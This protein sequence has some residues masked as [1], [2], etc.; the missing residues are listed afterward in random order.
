MDSQGNLF[1]AEEEIKLRDDKKTT[2]VN[3]REPLAARMRP[4]S[5]A[6]VVGQ[7]HLLEA[8]NLLPR[9]VETNSFG[10]LIFYGPPG[11]G[12]TSI[13][14]AIAAE[15]ESRYIRINAVMS[16]VAELREI[17][18]MARR[19]ET[20]DTVLFIDE[21][22]RFNRSQ[23]DLLLP[24]VEAGNIRLIGATTHNP[25]FYVN[26]P[27]LSRSH[28]FR[29]EPHSVEA[30]V[31][32]LQLALTDEERGL[33][34]RGHEA[35]DE[36]LEGLAK[37]CDGDMR[38]ALNAL[39]VISLGL[40]EGQPIDN[41]SVSVFA[42]ERQ[43]RYDANEDEHYN[44]ISAFIK[45]MRGGSPDSALYWLAKMMKGG[46]D[47]RFVARRLIVFCSEDIGLADAKALPLAVATQQACEFV[48]LP[49][50]EIN[51]AHCVAYC[52]AAPKSNTS[53]SAYGR[54]KANITAG[55]VQEVP[56]WLK[57]KGG[58][59]NKRLGH[60]RDYEYS[61][62]F[63]ENISGQEFMEQPIK[64]MN[65]KHVG[66]ESAIAD[67]LKRWEKLKKLSRGVDC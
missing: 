26:A 1:R 45:S 48:G 29:L 13:A 37:L 51:L 4:R 6:E 18:G 2:K 17:L 25:G 62:E 50:C 31:G 60:A 32:M 5:L 23:Q 47:P 40:E 63:Q 38:R 10:S 66:E 43:I 7:D 64:F 52:A 33:G 19:M 46:E 65:P 61:H 8:G 27:L 53:H 57:E 44:T 24:D 3:E 42:T 20:K 56:V 30:I 35:S 14:E 58:M 16:N 12:K 54:A 11:C 49:E 55:P 21:I 34:K 28:L 67:R 9:L 15:T 41:D 39:E 22:H 59:A 36:A